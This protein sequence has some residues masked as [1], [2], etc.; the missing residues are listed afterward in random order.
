MFPNRLVNIGFK[1]FLFFFQEKVIPNRISNKNIVYYYLLLF[2]IM[3]LTY[4]FIRSNKEFHIFVF[5]KRS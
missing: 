5:F 1:F 4:M 2:I 3:C